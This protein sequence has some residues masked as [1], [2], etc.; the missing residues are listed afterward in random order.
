MQWRSIF[1]ILIFV[2]E[3]NFSKLKLQKFKTER[4]AAIWELSVSNGANV[5]DFIVDCVGDYD[6]DF[7]V[8]Y[9]EDKTVLRTNRFWNPLEI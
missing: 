9:T 7:T 1:I 4:S 6:E 8:N 5:P 3:L 2:P